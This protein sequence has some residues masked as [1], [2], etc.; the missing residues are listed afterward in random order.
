LRDVL[1]GRTPEAKAAARRREGGKALSGQ[2]HYFLGHRI[3]E[4]MPG[5]TTTPP[6]L[7]AAKALIERCMNGPT[8]AGFR[9]TQPLEI[10]DPPP[11]KARKDTGLTWLGFKVR[12]EP[13]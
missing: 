3:S 2:Q 8:F 4:P 6:E 1:G 10:F 13:K 5:S 7:Q 11:S 9:L 12:E